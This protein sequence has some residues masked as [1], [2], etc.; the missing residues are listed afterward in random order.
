LKE[1]AKTA[2]P[3]PGKKLVRHPLN[4]IAG[5]LGEAGRIY[6][7]MRAG[8]IKHEEGRSL[9]W[10]LGVMKGMV[11]VQTL[12]RLEARLEEISAQTEHR[13]NGHQDADRAHRWAH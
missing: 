9:V 7:A 2:K 13:D 5:L 12:E 4:T 3:T 10:V 1:T 8:K 11:E 6:R